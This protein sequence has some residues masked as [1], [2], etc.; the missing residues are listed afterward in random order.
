MCLAM[1][2]WFKTKFDCS[3]RFASYM[4]RSSYGIYIV[5]YLVIASLG[6]MMKTYTQ[7]PPWSMYVILTVAV[8][9]L[10]PLLYE[11][12]RRIPVVRWCVLGE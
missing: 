11:I 8:F 10:S 5:H 4:T 2:G 6:Y 3:G 7:L 9:T 12:I 1:K